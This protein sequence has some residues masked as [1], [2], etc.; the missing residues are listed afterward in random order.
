MSSDADRV[1]IEHTGTMHTE[2]S[3]SLPFDDACAGVAVKP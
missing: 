2:L 1:A 3:P